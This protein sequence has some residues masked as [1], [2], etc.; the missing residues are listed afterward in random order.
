MVP[1][2]DDDPMT[3]KKTEWK[4]GEAERLPKFWRLPKSGNAG[5]A[6]G[7]AC[8]NSPFREIV[9]SEVEAVDLTSRSDGGEELAA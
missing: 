8:S 6:T 1:G 3:E 5:S 9:E 7:A 2:I 4:M